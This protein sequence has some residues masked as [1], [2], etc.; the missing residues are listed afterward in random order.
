MN[1][2]SIVMYHYVRELKN[3][4]YPRIKGLDLSGFRRQ[5]DYLAKNFNLVTAEQVIACAKGEDNLPEKSC[6]LTFD[7]GYKDHIKYV[8]PELVSRKIQGSFF[9]PVQPVV[10]RDILDVNRI[11]FILAK[12]EDYYKLAQELESLCL[13]RGLNHDELETLKSDFTHPSRHDSREVMY[14]KHMLQHGLS[15][16]MRKDISSVLFDK[17]VGMTEKDFADE[18]YLSV[19]DTKELINSGM[20]VGSH[21]YRHL[22]LNRET[23]N[24]QRHEIDLSL[25]FLHDVGARNNDWIMCYPYGAY[26]QDTLDLLKDRNCAAGLT[27]EVEEATVTKKGALELPRYDTND[28]PQ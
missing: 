4:K 12:T 10:E 2:L 26:N 17:Y 6:Y 5:L 11:H 14:V 22:W 9:I 16:G 28:F 18:L 20:Y 19:E 1:Q 3:S 13:D 27:T 24:S 15:E 25:K 21:G 8:L 23:V 7:D